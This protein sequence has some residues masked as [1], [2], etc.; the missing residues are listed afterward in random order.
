MSFHTTQSRALVFSLLVS[1]VAF[2]SANAAQQK[3]DEVS[4]AV[5]VTDKLGRCVDNLSQ[6]DFAVYDEKTR[7]EITSF[8]KE[9]GPVAIGILLDISGSIQA[10]KRI[11]LSN[12][13]SMLLEF[14]RQERATNAYF[15]YAFS[16]QPVLLIDWTR[17][18]N[19]IIESLSSLELN[20]RGNTAFYDAC[21]V[22]V[23]KLMQAGNP[24]RALVVISDA[25]DNNSK[26][27]YPKLREKMKRSD[28]T[29]YSIG[30]VD[31]AIDGLVGPGFGRSVCNELASISGGRSFF[32]DAEKDF[33][34][35]LELIAQYLGCRYR[36]GFKPAAQDGKRHSVKI[37]IASTDKDKNNLT[38]RHR[39]EYLASG[40]Q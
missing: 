25:S 1:L 11:R 16:G 3:S 32:P 13:K 19:S 15:I 20:P 36:I 27:I 35:S 5:T 22:A 8:S 33:R 10:Q 40:A 6:S 28:V 21:S 18:K 2:P 38:V 30:L 31:A 24:R 29:F 23:D 37:K 34:L 12:I 26:L 7:Q 39:P 14:F 9:E 17:D 4:F